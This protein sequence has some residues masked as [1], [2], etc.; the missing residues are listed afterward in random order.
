MSEVKT[1]KISPA[2]G[3]AFT[4]GDSG[5]TFTV[6]S[7]A[8]IVNSGT[9]TGFGGGKVAQ[10][11]M[12]V[13]PTTDSFTTENTFFEVCT[14]TIT[15]T[16]ASS[17]I[18]LMGTLNSDCTTVDGVMQ[19]YRD[20]NSAGNALIGQPTNVGSVQYGIS[21]LGAHRNGYELMTASIH[22]LDSPS[23][24]LTDA[25][26]Y[27]MGIHRVG[28]TTFYINRSYSNTG[29]AGEHTT[30]QLIAMEILA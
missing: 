17:K 10:V 20:I 24:T 3:T 1:N 6:P 8:S 12:D 13:N 22:Y 23:Y 5:D 14:L 18:L 27:Q 21:G 29:S 28:T 19:M 4:L 16:A 26:V 11:V 9:A 25:I 30:S 2:T 15:P 7:G